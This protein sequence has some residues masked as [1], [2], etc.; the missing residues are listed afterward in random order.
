MARSL[1]PLNAL[2]AFEAAARHESFT[3]AAEEFGITQTAVSRHVRVLEQHLRKALFLRHASGLELTGDGRLLYQTLSSALDSISLGVGE[4]RGLKARRVVHISVQP[5]FAMRWLIPHLPSFF[6]RHPSVDVH[7]TSSHRHAEFPSDGTDVAIRLGRRWTGVRAERLFGADL[8]PVCSPRLITRERPLGSPADLARHTLLH[9]S[10]S[11]G[12]WKVWLDAAGQSSFPWSTGS[13]FDSYAL[14]LQAA[15]EGLGVAIGRR[16]F[17]EHDLASGRLVQPFA[18]TVA[19][20][21][22][23]FLIFPDA[24]ASRPEIKAF[25]SW[26]V[27]EAAATARMEA[28]A[29]RQSRSDASSGGSARRA[30][31]RGRSR[32]R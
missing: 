13:R 26:I 7:V 16:A 18:L 29:R 15:V 21:E 20:D 10:T 32:P 27:E 28:L 6:S 3:K 2:R 19:V 22:A 23:W 9:V 31:G 11:P 4:I 24:V 30:K 25:R 1:P 14:T 8:F 12:D 5:N 17:V